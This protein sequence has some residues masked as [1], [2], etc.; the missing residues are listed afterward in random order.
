MVKNRSLQHSEIKNNKLLVT[1]SVVKTE[2]NNGI[3]SRCD[4]QMNTSHK[5]FNVQLQSLSYIFP[6]LYIVITNN[7]KLV[8]K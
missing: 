8:C 3:K 4:V 1:H 5:A 6:P 2:L 7:C